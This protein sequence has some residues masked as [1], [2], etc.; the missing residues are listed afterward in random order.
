MRRLNEAFKEESDKTKIRL[1]LERRLPAYRSLP[2]WSE[3]VATLANLLDEDP[4]PGAPRR[5]TGTPFL[6]ASRTQQPAP[7]TEL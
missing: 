1:D 2:W 3:G 4:S 7:P 5:S 6:S